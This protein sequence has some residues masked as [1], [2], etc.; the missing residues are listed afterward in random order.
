M[1]ADP[2]EPSA[3]VTLVALLRGINLGRHRRLS[4]ATLR[5]GLGEL[6]YGEVRT[7]GQSGNVVLR[8]S[9]PPS[10]VARAI[11]IE[12]E[13]RLEIEVDV[14]VRTADELSDL[15]AADPLGAVAGDPARHLV[16]FFP[17]EP[18]RALLEKFAERDFAPEQWSVRGREVHLWCPNGVQDSPLSKLVGDRRLAPT[19]T[20]RNWRTLTKVLEMAGAAR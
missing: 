20:V 7:Q 12:I 9:A 6:G 13:S 3:G 15:L 5:E 8:A 4:M 17:S 1:S 16:A 10:E 18:D 14:I 11:E 2:R 19:V